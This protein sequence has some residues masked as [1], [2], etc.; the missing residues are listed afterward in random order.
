MAPDFFNRG[1]VPYPSGTI[2]IW[3]GPLE[4]IP[5]GW[6]IC[7]GTDGTPN[8]LDRFVKSIPDASTEPGT[9]EGSDD[10]QLTESQLPAHSH[11]GQTSEDNSHTHQVARD[12]NSEGSYDTD[13]NYTGG[14]DDYGSWISLTA[15]GDHDHS[16]TTDETGQ[17]A[18][19]DNRPSHTELIFIQKK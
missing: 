1:N 11:T 19:I 9:V 5:R 3:I 17:S 2:Q 15:N 10:V 16:F 4:E 18:S 14:P 13:A 7:D 12:S 6:T 8:L